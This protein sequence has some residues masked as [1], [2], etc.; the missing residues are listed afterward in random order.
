LQ[1]SK[2]ILINAKAVPIF[3]CQVFNYENKGN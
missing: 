3:E 1:D 2:S